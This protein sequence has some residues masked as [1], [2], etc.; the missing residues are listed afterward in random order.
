MTS[1]RTGRHVRPALRGGRAADERRPAL[2]DRRPP[3]TRV[4]AR[5]LPAA[6]LEPR[7][8]V[9][10]DTGGDRAPLARALRPDQLGAGL[11]P[12]EEVGDDA[13]RI[14]RALDEVGV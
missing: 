1:P 12:A 5:T 9:G 7:G 6:R 13:D 2:P 11:R 4:G 10:G 14:L 8:R 3:G